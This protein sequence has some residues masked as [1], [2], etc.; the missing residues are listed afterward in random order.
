MTH[1]LGLSA[2]LPAL[3]WVGLQRG[4]L[5]ELNF[6]YLWLNAPNMSIHLDRMEAVWS[7]MSYMDQFSSS[8]HVRVVHNL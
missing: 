6:S 4:G 2:N 8:L 1:K 7:F 5:I 3:C